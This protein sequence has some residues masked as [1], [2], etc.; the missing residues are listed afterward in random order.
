MA[1]TFNDLIYAC[2]CSR[3]RYGNN[4]V[5]F[6]QNIGY[7]S[8]I[9]PELEESKAYSKF[10]KLS[11]DSDVLEIPCIYKYIISNVLV[12]NMKCLKIK[13]EDG[14]ISDLY[15][16]M[17][18]RDQDPR[19]AKTSATL[20]KSF[21]YETNPACNLF[22]RASGETTYLGGQGM[23]LYD[24]YTPIIMFT[25]KVERNNFSYRPLQQIAHINPAIFYRDDILAKYIKGKFLSN[26][27]TM[28]PVPFMYSNS[29][30][31]NNNNLYLERELP[32]K[33]KVI[34]EDFSDFFVTPT[35]PTTTFSSDN[36]N[37]FL[38]NEVE[39]IISSI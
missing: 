13:N 36:V 34:I 14:I 31:R 10:M 8:Y 19:A 4:I 12:E 32:W 38:S 24:D 7:Y 5:N 25:L 11:L 35:I 6:N 3:P 17:F 22:K 30:I 39:E 28:E 2:Y 15:I 29:R 16:P 23:L 27:I 20:L 21:F 1:V 33:F 18:Y 26:L 37:N 9:P